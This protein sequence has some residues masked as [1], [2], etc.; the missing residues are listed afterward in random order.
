MSEGRFSAIAVAIDGSRLSESALDLAT[1]MARQLDTR[2]SLVTVLDAQVEERFQEYGR[3]E[4]VDLL[5][6]VREYQKRWINSLRD[7]GLA[8]AGHVVELRHGSTAHTITEVAEN[9]NASLLVVGT[10]GR[11]GYRRVLGST[12]QALVEQGTIPVVVAR[13][14]HAEDYAEL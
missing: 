13:P 7:D 12:A 4:Q 6:A 14:T 8:V 2:I 9:V 10:H 11:H 1:Q 3:A 5:D